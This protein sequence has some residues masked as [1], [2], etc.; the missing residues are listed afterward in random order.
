MPLTTP[1]HPLSTEVAEELREQVSPHAGA[2]SRMY[3][4]SIAARSPA[5]APTGGRRRSISAS[6]MRLVL[7]RDRTARSDDRITVRLTLPRPDTAR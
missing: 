3:G 2:G 1:V 7:I 6:R 5:P 4:R